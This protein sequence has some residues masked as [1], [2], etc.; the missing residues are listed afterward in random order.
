MVPARTAL[1]ALALRLLVAVRTIPSA[2]LEGVVT[3]SQFVSQVLATMAPPA[4]LAVVPT[5][6]IVVRAHRVLALAPMALPASATSVKTVTLAPLLTVTRLVAAPM[7]VLARKA[8]AATVR[9]APAFR[10][11]SVADA[12]MALHAQITTANYATAPTDTLRP[13]LVRAATAQPATVFTVRRAVLIGH[14]AWKEMVLQACARMAPAAPARPTA[15]YT[16]PARMARNAPMVFARMGIHA[17]AATMARNAPTA[18]AATGP[19][20]ARV[21]ST[22]TTFLQ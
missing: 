1:P 12:M 20:P 3:A 13:A 2:S 18:P 10:V 6:H 14:C 7:T 16:R 22:H 11:N 21:V 17:M 19:H 15:H 4:L 5:I 8:L 9:Y